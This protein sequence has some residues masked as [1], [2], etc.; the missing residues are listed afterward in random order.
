M[1]QARRNALQWLDA[2]TDTHAGLWM[3]RYLSDQSATPDPGASSEAR[4]AA[5]GAKARVIRALQKPIRTPEDY[6][7]A[8]D[9]Q[10]ETLRAGGAKL[11]VARATGRIVVW[12]GARGSLEAGLCL[13]RT[14]GTPL[15]PGSS[16]K[17]V[18]SAA[19]RGCV[20]DS[21]WTRLGENHRALF[22]T[23]DAGGAVV[24]HDAWWVPDVEHLPIHLDTMTVHHADYYQKG[25]APT[26]MDAPVPVP[27]AA[28]RGSFLVALQGEDEAVGWASQLVAIGLRELGIGAKTNAG[29]GR[30]T[31]H[32]CD[33]SPAGLPTPR[34]LVFRD[35]P[36]T[37]PFGG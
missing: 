1:A 9:R 20:A 12:L 7:R 15:L 11:F 31:L 4:E 6:P 34:E 25:R 19:A 22:G 2:R 32:T 24:F 10:R 35:E 3:D 36:E 23:T 14:W 37:L 5:S 27:F 18:A 21:G 29:Y 16:I 28:V 8:F 33:L 17:G 13:E 30:M 26:E